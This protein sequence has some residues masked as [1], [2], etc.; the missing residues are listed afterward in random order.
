MMFTDLYSSKNMEQILQDK[1]GDKKINDADV[2]LGIASLENSNGKLKVYKI[3][4]SD[5]YFHHK[6]HQSWK[7]ALATF[8]TPLYFSGSKE[9]EM[10][11]VDKKF[12]K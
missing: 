5:K 9:L 3:A 6:D 1:F 4:H 12:M 11:N 8:V 2:I 10:D 7:V